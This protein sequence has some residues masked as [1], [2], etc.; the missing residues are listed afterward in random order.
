[1]SPEIKIEGTKSEIK[2][3]S[4]RRNV[5][6]LWQSFFRV[7]SQNHS[8]IRIRAATW[9]GRPD[10]GADVTKDRQPK[11]KFF[12]EMRIERVKNKKKLRG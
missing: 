7:K 2:E 4:P 12:L 3:A 11:I 8:D 1:M 9:T 6:R 10:G 5:A